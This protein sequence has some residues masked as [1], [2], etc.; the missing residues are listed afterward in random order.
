MEAQDRLSQDDITRLMGGEPV[1]AQMDVVAKLSA[2]FTTDG[3]DSMT[4]EENALA[5]DIFGILLGRAEVQVRKMI[6]LNLKQSDKLP[7]DLVKKMASDVDEVS[8]PVIEFSKL[9]TDKDLL[10][11][12]QKSESHEKLLSIAKRDTVSE[13]VVDA[14]VETKVEQVVSTLVVNEGAEI[15]E[16]TFDKIL[17]NHAESK[18]VMSSML[19]RGSLPITVVEKLVEQVSETIREKL[20]SQYGSLVDLKELRQTLHRS[21]ELTSLKLMGMSSSDAEL[22]RLIGYLEQGGKLS[23]FSALCMAN[24]NLFAVSMAR[25]LRVPYKNIQRL[26]QDPNGLKVMYDRAELPESMFEAVELCVNAIR[27][28]EGT[29]ERKPVLTPF[30]VMEQMRKTAGT[31]NIENLSYMYAMMQ[32]NTRDTIRYRTG[33]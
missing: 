16:E 3:K 11:I 33:N 10:E 13:S 12:I 20:E 17:N 21:M 5:T 24:L 15:K 27:E 19:E 8:L 4:P 6:A 30:Q 22:S 1:S 14:L 28:L 26:L 29:G 9:L 32:Q 23:P 2:H 18:E 31:R 25:L 7:V